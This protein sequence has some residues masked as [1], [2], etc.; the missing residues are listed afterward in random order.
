M[1][2]TGSRTLLRVQLMYFSRL[3]IAERVIKK[4]ERSDCLQAMKFEEND[5]ES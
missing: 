3:N 1:P 4:G 5:I 2:R